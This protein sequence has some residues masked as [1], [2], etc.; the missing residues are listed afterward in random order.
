MSTAPQQAHAFEMIFNPDGTCAH[1]DCG[2]Q[3][4]VLAFDSFSPEFAHWFC[5]SCWQEYEDGVPFLDIVEDR[6]ERAS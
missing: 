4:V 3:G 2:K 5:A 6:R 1:W